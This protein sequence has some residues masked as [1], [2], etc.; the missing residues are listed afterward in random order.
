MKDIP[1]KYPDNTVPCL[2][3]GHQR[4]TLVRDLDEID[5]KG[6]FI[7]WEKARKEL[8]LQAD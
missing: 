2:I 3:T 8:G 6:N 5:E 1:R 7:P 4:R